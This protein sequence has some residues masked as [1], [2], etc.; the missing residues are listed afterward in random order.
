MQFFLF[1]AFIIALALM[2]FAVQNKEEITLTFI[3]WSLRGPV[4][5]VLALTFTA[6]TLVGIFLVIPA[7]WRKAKGS[8]AHKKRVQELERELLNIEKRNAAP[9]EDMTEE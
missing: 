4:A 9:E 5:L 7:W 6:G 2:A 1:L 3:T 8:R